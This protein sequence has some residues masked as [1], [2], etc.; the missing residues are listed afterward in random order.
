MNSNRNEIKQKIKDRIN[1]EARFR[2]Y[3]PELY[4]STGNSFS[5]F[6]D[7]TT[8]SFQC[9]KDFGYDHGSCES[10]DIFTLYE[11]RFNCSF[12]TA[13]DALRIEAGISDPPKRSRATGT[14]KEIVAY[15]YVDE[16]GLLLYQN[17]RFEPKDFRTR[18]PDPDKTGEWIWNLNGIKRVPFKLPELLAAAKDQPVFVCEGEKDTLAMIGMGFVATSVGS[19]SNGCGTLKKHGA[20]S[21]F[22]DRSVIIIADKDDNGRKYAQEAAPIYVKVAQSVKIIEIPGERIK[23]PADFYETHGAAGKAIIES[24]VDAT[25]QFNPQTGKLVKGSGNQTAEVTKPATKKK[26]KEKVLSEQAVELLQ[27]EY[28]LQGWKTTEGDK[29]VTVKYDGHYCFYNTKGDPFKSFLRNAYRKRYGVTLKNNSCKDAVDDIESICEMSHDTHKIHVRFFY[30][31]G[32]AALDLCDAG[33]NQIEITSADWE[34]RPQTEPRFKRVAE[35][36]PLPMPEYSPTAIDDFLNVLT[37]TNKTHRLLI[38]CWLIVACIENIPRPILLLN[39]APGGAKSGLATAIRETI[40]PNVLDRMMPNWD[41]L[42]TL[43]IALG[44]CGIVT[45][46]NQSGLQAR[47]VNL[48]CGVATGAVLVDRTLYLNDELSVMRIKK[49]VI[50]TSIAPSSIQP[51]FLDRCLI[52]NR[53]RIRPEESKTEEEVNSFRG[54]ATE[55]F[56]LDL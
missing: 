28:D 39:G 25:T 17:V 51:D 52:I 46:E 31:K 54:V 29:W 6:R 43:K 41:D 5:P 13:F 8:P 23:D 22:E 24:I 3:Y 33:W 36:L 34:I 56:T 26:R 42:R 16:R 55:G 50:M 40:D 12:Q 11:H 2:E 15:D 49:P 14:K 27:N 48:L 32:K 20:V 1:F 18:R 37:V 53:E 21:Y 9:N 38:K 45:L 4:R 30:E 47:A 10:Y 19:A 35:T 7:E 44:H